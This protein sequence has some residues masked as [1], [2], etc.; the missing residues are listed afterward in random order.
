MNPQ[1]LQAA[2]SPVWQVV[3]ISFA[4]VLILF[5]ILRGWKRGVARQL[6]RLGALIAAYFVGFYAGTFAVP[7]L[8]P[9]VKMPDPVLSMLAGA[10]LALVVYALINGLGT[11]L[12]KRTSQHDSV[13]VRFFYGLS[14]A[15]L[16]IFFGG[17]LV[18]LAVFGIRSLGAVADAKVQQNATEQKN[19]VV[20]AVDWRRGLSGSNDESGDLMTSLARLKNSLELGVV[21]DAVKKADVV[22]TKTYETFGKL[23]KVVSDPD[24]AQRFLN[25]PGAQELSTN[26]KIVALRD[27]PEIG[28]MISQ[29]R[30]VELLQNQKIRDAAND[31]VLREAIMKFDLLGALDFALQKRPK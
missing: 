21:G 25:F 20:H 6:A 11:V 13:I 7:L 9:V 19:S 4:L 8:R 3:F 27:D 30:F 2:G 14:G 5:E 28:E 12:F 16:G 10:T 22:P 31:P 1:L 24:S 18:W 23:G 15:V 29:R 17:F 26:P